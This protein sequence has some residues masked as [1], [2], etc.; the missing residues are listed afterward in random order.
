MNLVENIKLLEELSKRSSVLWG[1]EQLIVL[2]EELG[3]LAEAIAC[4]LRKD[5]DDK[6][7]SLEYIQA[8]G[9]SIANSASY[10]RKRNRSKEIGELD[11]E[12][13][14]IFICLMQARHIF[15][16]Q[17]VDAGLDRK[18]NRWKGKVEEEEK[19]RSVE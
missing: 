4:N 6:Q 3:E 17:Y 15:G 9:N 19:R 11:S 8:L 18:V 14:D 10:M 5:G 7:S 13:A 16:E 2:L 1:K 12:I